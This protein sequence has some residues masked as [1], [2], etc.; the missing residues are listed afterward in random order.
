MPETTTRSDLYNVDCDNIEI[1]KGFNV[2]YDY[3]NM[4]SLV[5]SIRENGIKVPCRGYRSP[6][7]KGRFILTDGHRR[8]KATQLLKGEGVS[9]QLPM[10]L[11]KRGYTEEQRIVDMFICGADAKPLTMLEEAEAVGRLLAIDS[12]EAEAGRRIG[13]SRSQ[14]RLYKILLEAP[15][16][17]KQKV[18]EEVV[19]PSFVINEVKQFGKDYDQ[20]FKEITKHQKNGK[21]KVTRKMVRE[22]EEWNNSA[23]IFQRVAETNETRAVRVDR[24]ETFNFIRD[25]L[26]GKFTGDH[27]QKYFY[28]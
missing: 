11:E 10:V 16:K 9:I 1:E 17:L 3:G 6:K 23:S 2:R 20:I 22:K 4:E 27:L 8:L 25:L 18:R 14:V 26:D 15:E 24:Q 28:E 5:E 19:S 13:R 12:N 7:K 21:A